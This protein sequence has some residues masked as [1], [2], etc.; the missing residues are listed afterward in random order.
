MRRAPGP[1]ESGTY[2]P[3]GGA[4]DRNEL[5]ASPGGLMR[6]RLVQQDGA[7][8]I[9]LPDQ[10]RK[11]VFNLLDPSSTGS[12]SGPTIARRQV[13]HEVEQCVIICRAMHGSLCHSASQAI[14]TLT[15]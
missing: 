6:V 3:D 11:D 4:V 15:S 13:A 8:V 2:G 10:G 7:D 1:A 14:V 12:E 9:C 5:S